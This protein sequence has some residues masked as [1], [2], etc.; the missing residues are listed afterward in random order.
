MRKLL[1]I[2]IMLLASNIAYAGH[3]SKYTDTYDSNWNKTGHTVR[4]SPGRVTTYDKNWNKTGYE[5]RESRGTVTTY[6]KNWNKTGRKVN[7]K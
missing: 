2:L 6:D 7:R 4:E 5:V 1:L 3:E